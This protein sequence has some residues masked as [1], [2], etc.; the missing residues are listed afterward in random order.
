M[1]EVN[2][3]NPGPKKRLSAIIV[4]QILYTI[5]DQQPTYFGIFVSDIRLSLLPTKKSSSGLSRCRKQA[6]FTITC[7]P[8]LHIKHM[9]L[10]LNPLRVHLNLFE[11]VRL[12]NPPVASTTACALLC[13]KAADY[14]GCSGTGN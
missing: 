9:D 4:R 3:I 2:Y 1:L 13:N 11:P 8:D 10:S 12:P 5:K 14:C 7:T 6:A